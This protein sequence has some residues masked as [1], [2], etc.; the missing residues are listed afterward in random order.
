MPENHAKNDHCH[1]FSVG[2]RVKILTKT[3]GCY[4]SRTGTVKEKLDGALCPYADADIPHFYRV[5]LDEAVNIGGGRM[6]RSDVYPCQ[7][8]FPEDTRMKSYWDI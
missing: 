3:G 7:E 8:V 1:A 2:D 6:V 4:N 5:E